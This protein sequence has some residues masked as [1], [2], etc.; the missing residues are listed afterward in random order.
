M[1]TTS[2]L[3]LS[4]EVLNQYQPRLG[5]IMDILT[6]SLLWDRLTV[7]T[8]HQSTISGE[9]YMIPIH[10]A[11]HVFPKTNTGCSNKDASTAADLLLCF[12]RLS[13]AEFL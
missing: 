3:M 9:I 7:L 4:T 10:T 8:V 2:F 6:V 12:I 5:T 11:V 1:I 13:D